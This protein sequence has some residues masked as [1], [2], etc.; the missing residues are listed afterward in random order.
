MNWNTPKGIEEILLRLVAC[1]SISGTKEE[2]KMAK[3]IY[4]VLEEINYFKENPEYLRLNPIPGDSLGRYVVTALLKGKGDRAVILFGHHDI[5]DYDGYGSYKEL[6]LDPIKLTEDLDPEILPEEA[7]KDLLSGQWL[8]GRGVMDMKCGT[9]LQ[10]ALI[11]ELSH[12]INNFE[13]NIIF[14]SVPDEENNSAGMLAAV[15]MV[16]KLRKEYNLDCLAYI[17]TEPQEAEDGNTYP[18]YS[19]GVGKVLPIFYCIG[20]ETHASQLFEGL[21]ADSLLGEVEREVHLSMELVDQAHGQFTTPP[22]V[23]SMKDERKYYNVTTPATAYAYFNIFTLQFTP[24]EIMEKL[25]ELANKAFDNTLNK[26]RDRAKEYKEMT[27]KEYNCPWEPKVFTY[28][29]IYKYN[30]EHMGES[31]IYHMEDFIK[32]NRDRIHDERE[33]TIKVV[34]E[35]CR[36]CPNRDPKIIIA[37]GPPYYPH[38]SNRGETEKEKL[39]IKTIKSLQ[40]YSKE[41]YDFQWIHRKYYGISDISY[42][43]LQDADEIIEM[44]KPNMPTLGYT[45]FISLEEMAKLNLPVMN[46]GPIG[47]DGHKFTER[48]YTPFAFEILP[49]LL[50]FTVFKLL[51]EN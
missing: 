37:F 34:G 51:R 24:K 6:A 23:L 43:G 31:F 40:N 8:F 16:N 26:F 36:L 47:I 27:G 28:E 18:L 5:V 42:C 49:D 7:R 38:L 4:S 39:L 41:K 14:L 11:E 22:T 44:L 2:V 25:R 10:I 13:G 50:R 30:L 21:S 46:I 12:D 20:K 48:L 9:A 19:G 1:S 35:V 33:F 3:E 45:Y 15:P 32:K 29:E 17:N